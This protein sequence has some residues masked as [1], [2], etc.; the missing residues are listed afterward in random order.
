MA[1]L[2]KNFAY[3]LVATAPS[4]ATSG[5]SLV[6][7]TGDG[8]KFPTPPF[9]AVI[10]PAA[11]Q[12]TAANAEIVRVTAK[13]TDTLTIT[14][15]QESSSA[16]TVVIGDQISA[17]ITAKTLT[18][19]ENA[20]AALDTNGNKIINYN[21]T[22]SAVNWPQADNAAT[23]GA[24]TGV[25]GF[26]AVGSDTNIH[27]EAI[28]KG[29]GLTKISVLRQDDTTNSYHHNSVQLTGW[30][31]ITGTSGT[32]SYNET[33]TFGIT[34]AAK[35]IVVA[36]AGGDCLTATGAAYGNGGSVISADWTCKACLVTTTNFAIFLH[37]SAFS[38]NGF[39]FYQWMATG[40]L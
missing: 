26:E 12:P 18:D 30:G 11:S 20:A 39:I 33:V 38:A 34:F 4:P 29:N 10:W 36:C 7:S 1:D 28:G 15:A 21:P 35:P 23:A 3:S 6:V 13:S 22:A 9:N 27:F 31:V 25:V 37:T 2:H 24:G 32:V 8:T 19:L 5:T 40:E 17:N 16:R 14:R